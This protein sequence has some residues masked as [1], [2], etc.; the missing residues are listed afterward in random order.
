MKKL[1]TLVLLF[2]T[3]ITFSQVGI[4]TTNPQETLHV[5]GNASTVRV[6]GLSSTGTVTGTPT[7]N[8][9]VSTNGNLVKG[10][11]VGY[12]AEFT[13]TTSVAVPISATPATFNI[14]GINGQTITVP[15]DGFYQFNFS[16]FYGAPQV[17]L[18]NQAGCYICN[19]EGDFN[20]TVNAITKSSYVTST[21]IGNKTGGGP[22]T[23]ANSNS[24]YAL[25]SNSVINK[26]IYLTSGTYTIT[27]T[28]TSYYTSGDCDTTTSGFVGGQYG[29][30]DDCTLTISYLT[31]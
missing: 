12:R 23:T 4:G 25:S 11:T 31:N 13:Q 5:S 15:F 17:L 29:G 19:G 22:P 26:Q 8:V 21:S 9:S 7:S 3:L 14:P 24:F 1:I 6:D 28:F 20:L 18:P 2:T 10:G 30:S 27:S 16:G